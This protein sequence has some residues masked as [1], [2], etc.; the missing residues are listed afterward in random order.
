[1][2]QKSETVMQIVSN[3]QDYP[4]ERHDVTGNNK[5]V[6]NE[7]ERCIHCRIRYFTVVHSYQQ[8]NSLSLVPSLILN[9]YLDLEY[10]N[11]P[12]LRPC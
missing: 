8:L 7:G 3:A 6:L 9:E 2:G 5:Y 12:T 1:M 10:K 4:L 11:H